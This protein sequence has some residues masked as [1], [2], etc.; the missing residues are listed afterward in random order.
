MMFQRDQITGIHRSINLLNIPRYPYETATELW[1][2]FCWCRQWRKIKKQKVPNENYL[3]I[4]IFKRF[5]PYLVK[6]HYTL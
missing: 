2:E 6:I 5:G 3:N 4:Q 1:L